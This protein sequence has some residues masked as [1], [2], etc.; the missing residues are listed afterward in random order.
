MDDLDLNRWRALVEARR[1]AE[2]DGPT[3]LQIQQSQSAVAQAQA[4]LDRYRARG[5]TGQ[6]NTRSS[7]ADVVADFARGVAELE[8]RVKECRREAD[9]IAARSKVCADRRNNLERLL[10]GVQQWARDNS[11]NLPGDDGAVT[12]MSGF[13]TT[14]VHV[15]TPPGREPFGMP[16]ALPVAPR[17]GGGNAAATEPP[18]PRVHRGSSGVV[19][20]MSRVWP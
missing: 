20:T 6:V 4:D 9:R 1:N 5:A 16:S 7:P 2:H 8:G 11:I 19:R 17:Q 3:P 13:G 14:A 10:V 15:P 18:A 12:G